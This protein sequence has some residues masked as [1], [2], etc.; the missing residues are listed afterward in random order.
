MNN[1]RKVLAIVLALAAALFMLAGC[2]AKPTDAVNT[3]DSGQNI[4]ITVGGTRFSMSIS[5]D[6]R[7]DGSST[8]DDSAYYKIKDGDDN[9][10]TLVISKSDDQELDFED[11]DFIKKFDIGSP[12]EDPRLLFRSVGMSDRDRDFGSL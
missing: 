2:K 9:L 8:G 4:I 6:Y 7:K 11:E 12:D 10:K 5:A 3:F 1:K